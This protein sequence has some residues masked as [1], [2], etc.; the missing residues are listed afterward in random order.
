[1]ASKVEE[2]TAIQKIKQPR[3]VAASINAGNSFSLMKGEMTKSWDTK[4]TATRASPIAS[5]ISS[6]EA[7]PGR[8]SV[9]SQTLMNPCCSRGSKNCFRTQLPPIHYNNVVENSIF[10]LIKAIG[11]K[12]N[13]EI[14]DN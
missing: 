6:S 2:L 10:S 13:A 9:S 5:R 14:I 1:V 4:N 3:P 12:M 11:V 7:A 8:I